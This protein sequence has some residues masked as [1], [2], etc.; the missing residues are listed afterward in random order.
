MNVLF[1]G[2][3]D[4]PHLGHID[5]IRRCAQLFDAVIVGVAVNPEKRPFLSGDQR[6][7]LL[8]AECAALPTV[9]VATYRGA[10][11]AF[12]AA[13][14]CTVVV[15]G[16]RGAGDL[17]SEQ[18]M[19]E[20]N[21]SQGLDTLLLPSSSRYIHISSRLVRQALDA[22][23]PLAGLVSPAIAAALAARPASI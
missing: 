12:A 23:L 15:R 21:R 20:V 5:L 7:Q 2:S 16:V 18:A 14:G 3:F 1:P 13:H 8:Q 22:G 10:T 9:S 6:L 19:A 17:E 4:P 11:T